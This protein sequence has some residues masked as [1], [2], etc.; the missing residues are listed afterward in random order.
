ME[1]LERLRSP[2]IFEKLWFACSEKMTSASVGGG[3]LRGTFLQ[4]RELKES[5]KIVK[6][7]IFLLSFVVPFTLF[8]E[9]L[10]APGGH[11]N[12]GFGGT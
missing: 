8:T 1:R 10:N 11:P 9:A 12:F 7:Y 4:S 2:K 5:E 6:M 3:I